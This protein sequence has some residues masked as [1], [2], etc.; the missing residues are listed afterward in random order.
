SIWIF[1]ILLMVFKISGWVSNSFGLNLFRILSV[2]LRNE[3]FLSLLR[4]LG[5]V[6]NI[7]RS[8]SLL[9]HS[10]RIKLDILVGNGLLWSLLIAE[11][12]N[13]TNAFISFPCRLNW[14]AISKA[15]IP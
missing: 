5:L 12:S 3:S 10:V 4:S 11:V 2:L 7:S 9:P 15:I 6:T 8:N 14:W 13:I 1:L